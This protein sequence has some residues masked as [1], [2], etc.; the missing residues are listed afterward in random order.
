MTLVIVKKCFSLMLLKDAVPF[1]M[2]MN[3]KTMVINCIKTDDWIL[4]V[5]N[6]EE[7][8]MNDYLACDECDMLDT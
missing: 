1:S 4:D 3:L 8:H 2:K 5:L 6:N 7:A